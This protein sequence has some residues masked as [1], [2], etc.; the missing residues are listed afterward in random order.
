M[1]HFDISEF[2]PQAWKIISQSF[3][4]DKLAGTYLL[5]GKEGYG[6][7]YFAV[8][9]TA[10]FNCH[11]PQETDSTGILL[12]CRECSNCRKI[13]SLNFEGLSFALALPPHKNENEAMDFTNKYLQEKREEPFRILKASSSRNIPMAVSRDI[14]NRMSRIALSGMKRVVVFYQ[15]ELMKKSSADSLLKLIEEPPKETIIILTAEK[16]EYL[17]PT[18]QSRA[19]RI[20]LKRSEPDLI[21]KYLKNNYDISDKKS[22]LAAHISDGSPGEAIDIILDDAED[23]DSLRA[24]SFLLFRT[25]I[26]DASYETVS[27][28]NEMLTLNNRG[29]IESMLQFWQSLIR[30]SSNYAVNKSEDDI[31]NIDFLNEIKRL[32]QNFNSPELG[33]S[34]ADNIKITLADMRRNVHIQGALTAMVIRIKSGLKAAS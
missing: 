24:V 16:A 2:Q 34:M 17:L 5:L 7:F 8:S 31:V 26:D 18:I 32:S 19:Q 15:M 25:L 13:F 14:K 20:K 9:M 28:I 33:L 21:G 30:D 12:P 1:T 29:K 6:Q 11:S 3:K 27:H 10:L 23:N 4:S 22:N